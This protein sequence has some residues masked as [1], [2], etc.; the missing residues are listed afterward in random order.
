[1]EW[2]EEREE[3]LALVFLKNLIKEKLN[4]LPLLKMRVGLV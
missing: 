2:E 1:M 3:E 4:L